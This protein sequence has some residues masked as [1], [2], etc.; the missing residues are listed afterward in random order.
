M[1]P[2]EVLDEDVLKISK[3]LHDVNRP[4]KDRFRALFTLKNIASDLCIEEIGKGF[5]D[6]SALLKHELA[7][8]LGQMQDLRAIP[9]LSAVLEDDNQET[10]VRHEAGEALGAIGCLDVLPLLQKYSRHET[11]EIAETCQLAIE[12]IEWLQQHNVENMNENPFKSVDPAPPME[13]KDINELTNILLNENESL[14]ERYRAMFA[15]RNKGGDEEVK[16]LSKGLKCKSALFRHEIAFVLGQMSHPAATVALTETLRN[17][18]EHGMVRHECAEALGA[19][20]TDD[21]FEIL[22]EYATDTELVVR[23]SCDIALD[24]CDYENSDQFQYADALKK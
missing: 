19:I 21:C 8:C 6:P 7:Y 18:T 15:L 23:E 3:S 12:R 16:A 14:F 1:A 24:M 22:K 5:K 4:L 13:D 20:A 10:I 2:L 9:I 11:T 17:N